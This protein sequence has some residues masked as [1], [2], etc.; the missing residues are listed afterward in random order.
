MTDEQI[1][2]IAHRTAST[3][4]HRSDPTQHSY[5]FVKHTLLD[6]VRKL[7]RQVPDCRTCEWL[8]DCTSLTPADPC[9]NG[10]QY[11]PA[12]AVVLWRTE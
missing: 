10:D 4:A 9:I 3:Y 6:F 7:G 2:E 12:S 5:G 11:Q 8:P 1:L